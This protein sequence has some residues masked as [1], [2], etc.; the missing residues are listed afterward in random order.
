MVPVKCMFCKKTTTI[1]IINANKRIN[2]KV[3][4]MK[5]SPVYYC[6]DCKETFISKE[7]QDAFDY[8]KTKNLHGKALLFDFDDISNK[9][10]K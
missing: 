8:I 10:N 3:I 2:D 5:N 1:H 6:A 7:T 4:T 9:M